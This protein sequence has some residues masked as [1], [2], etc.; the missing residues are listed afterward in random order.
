MRYNAAQGALCEVSTELLHV[1]QG[2]G[3]LLC[4]KVLNKDEA[5]MHF[6]FFVSLS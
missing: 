5:V 1:M 6:K 2:F 4:I 3:G